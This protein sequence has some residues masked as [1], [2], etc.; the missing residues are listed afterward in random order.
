MNNKRLSNSDSPRVDR[1]E[2]DTEILRLLNDPLRTNYEMRGD[3]D[4]WIKSLNRLQS[5]SKSISV[6][7]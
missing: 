6:Q 5:K 7:L 4:I 1:A 2:L 3:G